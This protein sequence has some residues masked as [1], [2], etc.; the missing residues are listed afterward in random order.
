MN[1]KATLR[2]PD[3]TESDL[4]DFQLTL[5]ELITVSGSKMDDPKITSENFGVTNYFFFVK[6]TETLI[7]AVVDLR[8]TLSNLGI[9]GGDIVELRLCKP[10]P[11]P[12]GSILNPM[13]GVMNFVKQHDNS[14]N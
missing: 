13:Y 4:E 9:Q 10:D 5:G 7:D 11:Q 12:D 2:L 14:L 6:S 1:A 3:G 8:S